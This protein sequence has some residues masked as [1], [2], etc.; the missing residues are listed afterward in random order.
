M[1]DINQ[2]HAELPK[3][4]Y[5]QGY[6][7]PPQEPLSDK[8]GDD[9]YD[10]DTPETDGRKAEWMGNDVVTAD[11]ARKLERERDEARRLAEEWKDHA[12]SRSCEAPKPHLL[13]WE[14]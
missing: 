4:Q 11:F 3:D 14:K 9:M 1:N 5:E 10:K 13:P 8:L 6:T 2:F 12:L 7:N